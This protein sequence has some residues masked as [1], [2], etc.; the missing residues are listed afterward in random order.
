MPL[1]TPSFMWD[2]E[3]NMRV[4]T[5][6]DYD[7]LLRNLWWPRL[8]K[9]APKSE[10][11]RERIVWLLDSARIKKT[12]KGGYIP[13]EDMAAQTAEVEMESAAG[14]LKLYR[15]QLEDLDGIGVQMATAWSAGVAKYAAYWPQKELA[16]AIKANGK[17]YDNKAFFAKDHPVNPFKLSAG[18][19]AN[20]FSGAAGSGAWSP[21]NLGTAYPGALPIDESVTLEQA[22]TNI[23]K[24]I[25]YVSSMRMPNGEDPRNLRV[26]AIIVP[27]ALITRAVAIT[28]A[29]TIAVKGNVAGTTAASADVEAIVRRF[30]L[31]EPIEAPELGAGF[32][33][34][35]TD[36]YLAIEEIQTSDAGAF[37]WIP[38]EDFAVK[39]Y[40]PQTEAQ[41]DRMNELE[42][43]TQGRYGLMNGHPFCLFRCRAS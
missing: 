2:L 43:H 32:G 16:N 13:F 14:G 21:T 42:W 39:Y 33:G 17:T 11:K 40:G 7:R 1:L 31:G 25:A 27:P 6:N 28:N 24:A 9:E 35:D 23:S 29:K 15:N 5:L 38:R 26:S 19:Y 12:G 3:S 18:I 37:L 41:L 20:E 30:G 22:I 36:W 10:S 8:M 4:V 34:S